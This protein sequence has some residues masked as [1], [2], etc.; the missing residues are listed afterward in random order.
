ML[1]CIV[2]RFIRNE[3]FLQYLSLMRLSHVNNIYM[4]IENLLKPTLGSILVVLIAKG[5]VQLNG[6]V[7]LIEWVL[8]SGLKQ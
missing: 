5:V 4:Y 1:H 2:K 7:L 8:L 6:V 3:T